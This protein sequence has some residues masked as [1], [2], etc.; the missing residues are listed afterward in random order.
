[1]RTRT[2]AVLAAAGWLASAAIPQAPRVLPMDG[3]ETGGVR[4]FVPNGSV[5]DVAIVI[6]DRGGWDDRAEAL[7]DGLSRE[8]RLVLGVDLARYRPLMDPEPSGGADECRY[9]AADLEAISRTVQRRLDLA[10]YRLP[11]LVGIGDGAALAYG[12][13]AQAMPKT[14]SAGIGFDFCPELMSRRPLCPGAQPEPGPAGFRYGRAPDPGAPWAAAPRPGCTAGAVEAAL[15]SPRAAMLPMATAG[16]PDEARAGEA[17]ARLGA[18]HPDRDTLGLPLVEIPAVGGGDGG[19]TFAVIY[20]GDGGW[21]DLDSDLGDRLAEAGIPVV[22]V[23]SLRYFWRERTPGETA[24]DLGRIIAHYAEEWRRPRLILIGYSFGA[25]VIPYALTR[26]PQDLRDRVARVS[27]LALA[28]DADF[29]VHVSGWIG[30]DRADGPPTRAEVE[31]LAAMAPALPMQCVYG[32]DEAEDSGCTRGL[33][34]S[35]R[36]V[37]LPGGHHFDEDY[38]RL[39]RM[40][41]E[42]AL[43]EHPTQQ[44][45]THA[46]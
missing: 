40:V 33:P 20:S 45:R 23:D 19:D 6:S 1:M 11:A 28:P 13:L 44:Q 43:P 9:P 39:A 10:G 2:L 22:G 25:D 31:R 46:R 30:A 29:E 17:L 36:Q 27:L 14:F 7:A 34:P 37:P 38:A 21:R 4:A 15:A 18:R 26:L 41:L 35:V 5:E 12:A 24:A 32:L 8:G 16:S 42:G 3:E